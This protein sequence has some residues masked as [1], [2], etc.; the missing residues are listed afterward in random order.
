MKNNF[1]TRKRVLFK[2]YSALLLMGIL[3]GSAHRSFAHKVEK[4]TVSCFLQGETVTIHTKVTST[5][6][7]SYSHWQYRLT[8]GGAWVYLANGNNNINGRT[9]YITGAAGP[10]FIEDSIDNLVIANVG[11]PAYTTQLDNVEFRVLMTDFGQDPETNPWPNIPV[12][13]AEEY[14]DLD[15]KYIRIRTRPAGENCFSSCT[16]NMLVLNPA[17]VPPPQ[18][19]Y[20]GGFEVPGGSAGNFSVPGTNGVTARAYTDLTEWTGGAPGTSPRYRIMGNPDSMN[21]E[22][23]AFA[24]HTGMN[25]LVVNANNTCA[26]RVWYRTITVPNTSQFFQGTIIF[27]GWFARIGDNTVDPAVMLEIKGGTTVTATTLSY[28]SLGNVTQTISGA[29]GTWVQLSVMVTLPVNTY[30]K[31]EIS[32]KTPDACNVPAYFAIDDL[33]LIEPVSGLLPIVM[34]PLKA[35]YVNGVS[36]LTWSSLQEQNTSYFEIQKSNDGVNFDHLSDLPAKGSSDVVV[37]YSFDDIKANAGINYYRLK[38]MDRDG[39][40][41]YSNIAAV[42][43]NIKGIHITGIYPAPFI[44]KINVTVSSETKTQATLSL[45]DNAGKLLGMQQHMVNKGINNLVMGDLDK[46]AK[47]FYTMRIQ[48]GSEITV[49]KLIK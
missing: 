17:A 3:L 13:G 12:Y 26:D 22:F 46:L 38:L 37:N 31:L 28:F 6:Y 4:Y 9:F 25:M 5:G 16:N 36:H 45:F 1:T 41:Q 15:A 43:V 14:G 40:Y 11:S 35:A 21:T 27:R 8:P 49:K 2:I 48:V 34:T 24:P 44:N 39:Q 19:D 32:I 7:N 18:E 33:C 20:F 23:S 47:G 29:A 30:K 42:N 10:T